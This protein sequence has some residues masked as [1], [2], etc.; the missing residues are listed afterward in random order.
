MHSVSRENS[1]R[2][3]HGD[4]SDTIAAFKVNL[5]LA[6]DTR[7]EELRIF[8]GDVELEDHRTIRYYNIPNASVL[9]PKR[10]TCDEV[11][12]PKMRYYY[13]PNA[14]VLVPK[15]RTCDEV[16][17]REVHY[18]GCT[19]RNCCTCKRSKEGCKSNCGSINFRNKRANQN[20]ICNYF[21]KLAVKAID[22]SGRVKSF[23]DRH[24]SSSVASEFI[25]N[26]K[27]TLVELRIFVNFS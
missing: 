26:G 15:R 27:W 14:S 10:R 17:H 6:L 4:R 21:S 13:P 5:E 22:D 11:S 3:V 20:A 18:S 7:A 8:F 9:V 12:L 24:P 16:S 23:L 1:K 2:I 19:N 25:G